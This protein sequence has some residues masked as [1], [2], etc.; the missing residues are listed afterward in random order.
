MGNVTNDPSQELF[1]ALHYM[2]VS[3]LKE[4]CTQL[5][6][7]LQ[8]K[9]GDLIHRIQTFV[10]TGQIVILKSL[11]DV[12]KAQKGVEYPLLPETLALYGSYKNDQRTRA[13]MKTLVGDHFHF[14]AFGQD[15]MKERW[16]AGN[17]P[18]YREFAEFWQAEYVRRQT[19]KASPKQEWAYLT[20][21]QKYLAEHPQASK[22]TIVVEWEKVRTL[23]VN[24]AKRILE[25][26]IHEH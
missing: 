19:K 20:F 15:W 17:P 7:P 16:Q 24:K 21:I 3:E 25:N 22:N 13:F 1:D 8:G 12:S 5:N 23:K 2:H 6:L 11:P 4:V 14:T 26:F 9:K 10:Q 18:T